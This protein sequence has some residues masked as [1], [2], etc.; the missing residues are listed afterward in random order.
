MSVRYTQ[1]YRVRPANK[2]KH[3]SNSLQMLFAETSHSKFSVGLLLASFFLK[4]MKF[5]IN[6]QMLAVN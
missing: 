4:A 6:R 2:M 1:E 3:L 5:L